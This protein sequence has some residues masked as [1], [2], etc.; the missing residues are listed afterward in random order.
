MLTGT[1]AGGRR[2]RR[3]EF[4]VCRDYAVGRFP[5]SAVA[6]WANVLAGGAA[7]TMVT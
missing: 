3:C 2:Q 5:F 6:R 4:I 1:F 7:W